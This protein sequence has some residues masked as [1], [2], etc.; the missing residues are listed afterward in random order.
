MPVEDLGSGT[1]AWERFLDATLERA[2]PVATPRMLARIAFL[3]DPILE[4][5]SGRTIPGL[6]GGRPN[7]AIT[8]A[9]ATAL[10]SYGNPAGDATQR[11]W[12]FL[13]LS[14]SV[15]HYRE[16]EPG[17]PD[18]LPVVLQ[19]LKDAVSVGAGLGPDT[20]A[21]ALIRLADMRRNTH[22][23]ALGRAAADEGIGLLEEAPLPG[24]GPL[25][26]LAEAT[27][28]ADWLPDHQEVRTY[29]L[30]KGLGWS[31]ISSRMLRDFPAAIAQRDRQIEKARLLP[32][33]PFV[34]CN[35][36]G[37]RA[38]LARSLGDV[39]TAL[40]LLDEQE[41][42]AR[43][44]GQ[45]DARV[46][47]LLSAAQSALFFDDWDGSIRLRRERIV[48]RLE[49]LLDVPVDPSP[50][51]LLTVLPDLKDRGHRSALTGVGNDAYDSA[52]CLIDSGRARQDATVREE[53]R[54]YL[55]VA[56]EAWSDIALNGRTAVGF[57]RLELDALEGVAGDPLT[58]GRRMVAYSRAWRRAAGQRRSA[59][60]A[61]AYGAPG[62]GEVLDRLNELLAGAP[63]VEAAHLSVGI[64][65]WHL[66]HGGVL[67]DGGDRLA[68]RL[69]WQRAGDA[70]AT[71]I[72]GL[73][74]DRA[75]GPPVLLNATEVLE[76]FLIQGVA[77]RQRR[78]AGDP[79]P[80]V[81]EGAELTLRLRSLP[82]IA[83]RFTASGTPV[84]RQVLDRLYEQWLADT[85]QL[86]VRQGALDSV[87]QTAEV[88][89]RDLVGAVLYAIA[90][91]PLAPEQVAVL[92]RQLRASLRATSEDL[93][94]ESGASSN[95]KGPGDDGQGSDGPG[96]SPHRR[97]ANV[98]AQLDKTLDVVGSVLGPLA[99][100]MFDPRT[101]LLHTTTATAQ[102][103]YPD[104][105]GAVLSLILFHSGEEPL[106]LRRMSWRPAPDTELLEHVDV[107]P[108]PRWLP[109]LGIDDHPDRFFARLARLPEV[110]LPRPLLDVLAAA[111]VDHPLPLT[112]I[113][114]GLLTVPFAALQVGDRLLLDVAS[115]A[116][117]QSLQAAENLSRPGVTPTIEALEVGVYDTARLPFARQEWEA[118]QLH[119]P[120]TR[121]ASSI[122]ELAAL[123]GDPRAL[124][125][126]GVLALAVHGSRGADGWT[127]AK[128]LPSGEVLTSVHV[129]E[130]YLPQ[131][132]VGASCNTDIRADAG[133]ELGGFP[134][135][136]QL[137]GAVSI[138]G[139]LHYIEDEATAQ[140]MALFY[141]ATAA[142]MGAAAALRQAQR[143][144][145][146]ADRRHRLP[147]MER[148]AYLLCYG[149]SG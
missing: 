117:V 8:R 103:L 71:A 2:D 29:L 131:L 14:Q 61:V 138:V 126:P 66:H 136:F 19:R 108:A 49:P 7:R 87:D 116:V 38:E 40:P 18:E 76:A 96:I 10:M 33:R 13:G 12:L 39:A 64:A 86:A 124:G 137:R 98:A 47:F 118:L 127:Q 147:E 56:A 36:L 135:A 37:Q 123:L 17:E 27:G 69:A 48:T 26:A 65:N 57:R 100:S 130:W 55:D 121:P 90:D 50:A 144:W 60:K 77:I 111:D 11:M 92:A 52:R 25:P 51:G 81:S 24:D 41:E 73:T 143:S 59:I 78:E 44:S 30:V 145:I 3:T 28:H 1:A 88:M 139:S 45:A 94:G 115:L 35:A 74:V 68:A 95:A 84:Q 112:V 4:T 101:V 148:W 105:A 6:P 102:R 85:L 97:A 70:A 72:S 128:Q 114:T 62:D 149:L 146:A 22:E 9:A 58:V 113:P 142:G 21:W 107:V 83:Q 140:I 31:A 20:H 110:L 82:A 5:P 119:H 91:N 32:Q 53:A 106:V 125:A 75:D 89:R 141:A 93:E 42:V 23:H 120:G 134:L 109:G 104:R 54:G 133:G 132:V 34:L 46:R 43:R 67:A 129:L 63:A 80:E 79:S 122:R 16:P 99:R 15:K